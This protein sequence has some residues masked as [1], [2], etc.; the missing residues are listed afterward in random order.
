MTYSP[1]AQWRNPA[2]AIKRLMRRPTVPLDGYERAELGPSDREYLRERAMSARTE[3]SHD[4]CF[5]FGVMPRSGTNYLERLL[6]AHSEIATCPENLREL[7]FLASADRLGEFQADLSRFYPPNNEVFRLHEWLA[8]AMAG[9]VNSI[10]NRADTAKKL[11]VIKDPHMRNI[12]IFDAIMPREKAIL[13]VRDGRYVID[14]TIRTWPLKPL[15]RTFE[16]VCLE[17]QAA[18]SAALDYASSAPQD[19]V[20]LVRYED[21]V[22]DT[23]TEMNDIFGWLGLDSGKADQSKLTDAPI[24]GSSTHSREATGEVGWKPVKDT[25]G[26]NPTSRPLEWTPAQRNTFD[27]ICGET[28]SKAGYDATIA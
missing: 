22:A 9:Y 27:R 15:G 18:T 14:S 1:D 12:S 11:T 10:R 3:L 24:L 17:W 16:D 6:E 2:F 5:V 28:Q 13:V 26:F 19:Q 25:K 21:L 23:S 8:Y 7:P 4:I 20:K